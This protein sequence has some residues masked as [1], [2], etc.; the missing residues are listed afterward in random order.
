MEF[1]ND[2]KLGKKNFNYLK[3]EEWIQHIFKGV[4][5]MYSYNYTDTFLNSSEKKFSTIESK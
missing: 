1:L 4:S 5:Q 3:A 2:C